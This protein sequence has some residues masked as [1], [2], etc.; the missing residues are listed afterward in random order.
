MS[1]RTTHTF[2]QLNRFNEVCCN[3]AG[4]FAWPLSTSRHNLRF[5][6]Y[7]CAKHTY[8]SVE[9]LGWIEVLVAVDY[10]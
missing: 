7:D 10:S 6:Q 2:I 3:V 1:L 4:Q 8:E 5:D 9:C